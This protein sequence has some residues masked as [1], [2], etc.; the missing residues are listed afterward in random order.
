MSPDTVPC[1]TPGA[2][3][4]LSNVRLKACPWPWP[5]ASGAMAPTK[6]KATSA[7]SASRVLTFRILISPERLLDLTQ[8][9]RHGQV[10][11]AEASKRL[12]GAGASSMPRP[13]V[14][15]VH[16]HWAQ[17]RKPTGEREKPGCNR[18]VV[19]TA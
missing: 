4:L 16:R 11:A 1:Q 17:P 7:A 18:T 3:A 19:K 9:D 13:A 6:Q 5:D 15:V 12:R 8:T 2:T 14:A 10:K